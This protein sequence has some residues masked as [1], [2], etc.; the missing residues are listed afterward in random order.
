MVYEQSLSL[1]YA[2]ELITMDLSDLLLAPNPPWIVRMDSD[3][4]KVLSLVTEIADKRCG[5]FILDGS[6]MLDWAQLYA[7]FKEVFVL[8]EYQGENLNALEE[9]LSDLDVHNWSAVIIV[10]RNAQEMLRRLAT[11]ERQAMIDLL[12]C[13]AKS[14]S[15]P[16]ESALPWSRQTVPFHVVL[17]GSATMESLYHT[18]P[19]IETC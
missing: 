8:P 10:V 13:V 2:N 3:A 15:I 7:E 12:V 14:Y 16:I 17:L 18:V 11:L 4:D 6:R 5:I 1:I 19:K 9:S